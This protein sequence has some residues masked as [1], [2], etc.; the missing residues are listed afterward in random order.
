MENSGNVNQQEGQQGLGG[1]QNQPNT[2]GK[3]QA[4]PA[5]EGS[6]NATQPVQSSREQQPQRSAEQDAANRTNAGTDKNVNEGGYSSETEQ[7]QS[8]REQEIMHN[9]RDLD[10]LDADRQN[11]SAEPNTQPERTQDSGDS[12]AAGQQSD[13]TQDS[14][15]LHGN[16]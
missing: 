16:K 15:Q 10:S 11:S 12:N 8:D 2:P 13:Y 1:T 3:Q 7:Q 14:R 9:E 4:S 6:T 5:R